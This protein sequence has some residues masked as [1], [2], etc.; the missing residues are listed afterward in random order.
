[1]PGPVL[2]SVVLPSYNAERFLADAAMSVL[3]QTMDDLELLIVDDGSSDSSW[4]VAGEL[5]AADGRVR[6]LRQ[7][8][9]G[10]YAAAMNRGIAEANGRY[11]ARMDAD[12]MCVPT[13]LERQVAAFESGTY[14]LCGTARFQLS[15]GGFVIPST[16]EHAGLVVETW[17]DLMGDRR[18]FTDSSVL[19][20]LG[21]VRAV[22][23]Y[24]TYT[25]AGQDVDLWF[26]LIER[27][28]PV[29]AIDE[30]LYGRRLLPGAITFTPGMR[31]QKELVRQLA[32]ERRDTGTDQ[33][34]RG[35]AVMVDPAGEVVNPA[36][37][38]WELG[39]AWLVAER[40]ARAGD[41]LGAAAFMRSAL[42]R[43]CPTGGGMVRDA[44][45][46]CRVAAM[47]VKGLLERRGR[48]ARSLQ[49]GTSL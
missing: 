18:R 36:D 37:A 20:A 44:R 39:A 42:Q 25:R 8:R 33:V 3:T 27:F 12:D 46:V 32:R 15:P 4:S 1:M 30:P 24:R 38:E 11:L 49:P 5:S 14:S 26:R 29:V 2:V 13:R 41:A 22:G 43:P 31:A 35:I 40:S 10:G 16:S 34:A 7:D 47:G 19:T 28:G 48:R 9:N 17:D 23:G 6:C 21:H 45:R